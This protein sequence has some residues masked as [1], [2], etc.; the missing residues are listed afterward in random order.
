VLQSASRQRA[1]ENGVGAAD[2]RGDTVHGSATPH[3]A[4]SAVRDAS[5]SSPHHPGPGSASNDRKRVPKAGS[6]DTRRGW[7]GLAQRAP[8]GP[9]RRAQRPNRAVGKSV[10]PTDQVA[11]AITLLLLTVVGGGVIAWVNFAGTAGGLRR[12]S[13]QGS[14]TLDGRPL[15]DGMV[16]L[17]PAAGTKGP[18]AGSALSKGK[19]SIAVASGPVVGRYRVEIMAVRKTGRKVKSVIPVG[20]RKERDETEQFIPTRYNTA[21]ELEVEIK[22]GRNK[23]TLELKSQFEAKPGAASKMPRGVVSRSKAA[24]DHAPAAGRPAGRSG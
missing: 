1:T 6:G 12:A 19:F 22:P 24:P 2:I 4:R 3:V 9:P 8:D 10:V 21:S 23:I 13:V 20:G 14:V 7:L 5:S 15:E 16:V 11:M 17:T 18:T